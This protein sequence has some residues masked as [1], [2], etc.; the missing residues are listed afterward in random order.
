MI[1]IVV[2]TF[3]AYIKAVS[4]GAEDIREAL[5]V[6]TNEDL[7]KALVATGPRVVH[8]STKTRK[9]IDTEDKVSNICYM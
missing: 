8:E 9:T 1:S 6:C 5:K 2:L 4:G 3:Q 7:T